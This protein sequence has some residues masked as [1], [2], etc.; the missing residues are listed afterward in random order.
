LERPVIIAL[1]FS[2][3]EDV[4]QFL[5]SFEARKPYVKVGMELFY[6]EGPDLIRQLKEKGFHIF[7]DLKLHDI[8]TT[9]YKAMR[10]LARLGVDIINVHA[11]GG[12]EM[13][14]RAVEGLEEGAAAGSERP[15]CIAVT[16]LTSTTEKMMKDE[17]RLTGTLDDVVRSYALLAQKSGL[18]GVVCSPL[19]VPLV[20]NACGNRFY[21]VTP[22]IRLATDDVND[23]NRIATPNRAKE[24]GCDAIVVGRSI[25]GAVHPLDAYHTIL[26]EWSGTYAKTNC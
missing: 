2:T 3:K 21:T 19:E 16:Q 6:Q 1:D 13:M 7:L 10:G 5:Q 9:A 18:D 20:K 24:L 17:L 14:K 22:G 8:P 11:A 12:S 23:Q 4:F 26:N 25:T 15:K